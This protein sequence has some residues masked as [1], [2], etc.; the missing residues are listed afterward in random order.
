[1]ANLLF[2]SILRYATVAYWAHGLLVAFFV[3]VLF[4]E[5]LMLLYVY[6]FPI[7]FGLTLLAVI[8]GFASVP[9][10]FLSLFL[11][12]VVLEDFSRLSLY[13]YIVTYVIIV[14]YQLSRILMN[15]DTQ[16]H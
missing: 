10:A 2:K 14:G 6:L 9:T 4:D 11:I 16:A 7:G 8:W 15:Q 13:A 5:N 3:M 1:M 12:A